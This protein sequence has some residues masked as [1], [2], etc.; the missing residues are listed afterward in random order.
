MRTLFILWLALWAPLLAAHE[1]HDHDDTPALPATPAVPYFETSAGNLEL[2]G[3]LHDAQLTLWLDRWDSNEPIG[4]AQIEIES[5]PWRAQAIEAEPGVYRVEAAALEAPGSHPLMIFVHAVGVDE[6]LIADLAVKAHDAHAPPAEPFSRWRVLAAAALLLGAFIY[7]FLRRPRAA[8]AGLLLFALWPHTQHAYA[9]AG[10]DEAAPPPV[11]DGSMPLRLADGG[12]FVP[13]PTQRLIGLRTLPAHYAELAQSIELMGRVIPDIN[14]SSMVQA[15]RAGR[16]SA[17]VDGLP[18]LGQTVRAGQVLAY[19]RPLAAAVDYGERAAQLADVK[20]EREV[21][22]RQLRR[23]EGMRENVSEKDLDAAAV[24]ARSLRQQ[25]DVLERSLHGEEALIAP[26]DGVISLSAARVGQV[27][28]AGD[29]L[30]E[31]IQPQRLWVEAVAYDSELGAQL[32]DASV[33]LA[34]GKVVEARF[35]GAGARLR[36]QALP[37]QFALRPPLPPIAVDEKV[38]VIAAL[39]ATRR[40]VAVPREAIVRGPDG[41]PRV[42][43]KQ[44]AER[45]RPQRVSGSP[46]NGTEIAVTEG[47]HEG[48]RIVVQGAALL[49]QIR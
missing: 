38:S 29:V 30:F 7:L 3:R 34:S 46:L 41:A 43:L 20:G 9:H 33:R 35:I 17:A 5:D 15:P 26:G 8:V 28:A 27:V 10:H 40:G 14:A 23:L 44:G 13:K 19:L 45:Y 42:W 47:L 18:A 25:Q 37:L 22:E 21:A 1:G 49:E 32:G 36:Q 16:L 48:D 39:G 12:L 6:I 4:G 11:A 24:A 31:I 2:S